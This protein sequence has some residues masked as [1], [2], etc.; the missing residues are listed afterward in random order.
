MRRTRLVLSVDP[1]ITEEDHKDLPKYQS[2]VG[3]Y[4]RGSFPRVRARIC[5][6][7]CG[8]S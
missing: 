5:A 1:E 8:N 3:D 6:S 4:L 2:G 7:G